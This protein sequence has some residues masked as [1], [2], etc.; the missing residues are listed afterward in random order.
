MSADWADLFPSLVFSGMQS[1]VKDKYPKITDEQFSTV[2]ASST[3]SQFPFIYFE[4]IDG[5]ENATDL[6]RCYVNSATFVF[7]ITVTS[8][9]SQTEA[10]SI[11]KVVEMAMKKMHF[12]ITSFPGYKVASN[13]HQSTSIF[14][15]KIDENDII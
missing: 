7:Q 15:R 4:M 12:T 8:N 13:V 1:A 11:M 10:K 3:K 9:N 2:S 5:G 6:E 14:K